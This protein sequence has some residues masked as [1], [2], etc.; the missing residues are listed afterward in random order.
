MVARDRTIFQDLERER[1]T[2]LPS[3]DKR[4]YLPI[5]N[6]HDREDCRIQS[7]GTWVA[8]T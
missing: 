6:R 7:S 4:E 3:G 5:E 1:V 2:F 8:A